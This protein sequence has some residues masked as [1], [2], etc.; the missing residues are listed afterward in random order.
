[1][2]CTAHRGAAAGS[3]RRRADRAKSMQAPQT[4]VS[5]P[6]G[7]PRSQQRQK[8]SGA[9]VL[10]SV[11]TPHARRLD[12]CP[13]PRGCCH[14]PAGT[15]ESPTARTSRP[16]EPGAGTPWPCSPPLLPR[17]T[18]VSPT[19]GRAGRRPGC[20][21]LAFIPEA[22]LS[23]PRG[24]GPQGAPAHT[25]TVDM[26]TPALCRQHTARP[27]DARTGGQYPGPQQFTPH[28]RNLVEQKT[29]QGRVGVPSQRTDRPACPHYDRTT[30][31]QSL[32]SDDE[33]AGAVQTARSQL[34][35]RVSPRWSRR[36]HPPPPHPDR[37]GSG[38]HRPAAEHLSPASPRPGVTS[39]RRHSGLGEDTRQLADGHLGPRP[40][41]SVFCRIPSPRDE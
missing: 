19:D 3:R 29:P 37:P 27:R 18:L 14:G 1:M 26:A 39:F 9:A 30:R 21:A 31:R 16:G 32:T 25:V 28:P 40:F 4:F 34:L 10:R 8:P 23:L 5:C 2:D 20:G 33:E 22:L 24:R 35:C 7:A 12:G 11:L 13:A 15:P 36:S 41:S 17:P 6:V 38:F